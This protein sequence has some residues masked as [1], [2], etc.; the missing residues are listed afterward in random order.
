MLFAQLSFATKNGLSTGKNV[1][2]NFYPHP[3][4][5]QPKLAVFKKSFAKQVLEYFQLTII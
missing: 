5:C 4:R 3:N 2:F 1:E